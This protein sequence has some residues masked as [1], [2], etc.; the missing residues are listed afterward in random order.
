[1]NK[2]IA[3]LAVVGALSGGVATAQTMAPPPPVEEAGPPPPAP[4]PNYVLAPGYY[5]W[6][7]GQYVWTP[8]HW[9]VGRVGFHWVP[10]HWAVGRLGRWHF[11]QGHW[12]R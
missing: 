4:G 5:A 7:N 9:I 8:R 11:V 10:P 6:V 2:I 1:M 3:A 12:A